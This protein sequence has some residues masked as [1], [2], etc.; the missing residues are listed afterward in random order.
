MNLIKTHSLLGTELHDVRIAIKDAID[1]CNET[2]T[3]YKDIPEAQSLITL[4]NNKKANLE[5]ALTKLNY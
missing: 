3:K 2:V 4:M 5:V 1:Y